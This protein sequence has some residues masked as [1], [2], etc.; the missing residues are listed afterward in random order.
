MGLFEDKNGILRCKGRTENVN[1]PYETRFPILIPR[2]RDFVNLV[3][4]DSH[5]LVKHDEIKETLVQ[6]R[7][8]F[9]IVMVDNMCGKLLRNARYVCDMK[10]G[11]IKLQDRPLA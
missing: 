6:L 2:D 11:A 3:I 5:E 8:Q 4:L 10:G 1:L 9:C 7:S